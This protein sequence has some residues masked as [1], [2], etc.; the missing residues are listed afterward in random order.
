MKFSIGEY[1]TRRMDGRVGVVKRIEPYGD[2]WLVYVQFDKR[3]ADDVWG[4]TEQAWV[5]NPLHAHV[6]T[7]SADCDGRYSSGRVEEMTLLERCDQFGELAFKDRV[8]S[9][10]VTMHGHGELKV[11]PYRLEW[12]EQTDEGYRAADVE[13]CSDEGCP[14]RSWQRDHS[15]EAAGY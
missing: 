5:R 10:V 15:A 14:N 9:S 1:V 13:W 7:E 3:D 8:M 2:E 12:H 4:G 6:T 11:T